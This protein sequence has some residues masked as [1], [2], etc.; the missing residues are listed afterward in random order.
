MALNYFVLATQASYLYSRHLCYNGTS[1]YERILGLG[2]R[3]PRAPK[4]NKIVFFCL[5][6]FKIGLR[7]GEKSGQNTQ[8]PLLGGKFLA[9]PPARR[10]AVYDSAELTIIAFPDRASV[11]VNAEAITGNDKSCQIFN[12]YDL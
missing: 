6:F 2:V 8:K 1:P 10:L 5:C 11:S 4:P 7:N 9:L 3:D 12:A